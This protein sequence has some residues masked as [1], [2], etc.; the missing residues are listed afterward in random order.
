MRPWRVSPLDDGITAKKIVYEKPSFELLDLHAPPQALTTRSIST[1]AQVAVVDFEM[2]MHLAICT[3]YSIYANEA[4]RAPG[5][6]PSGPLFSADA[7][8]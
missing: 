6:K 3:K 2:V 5:Q 1:Q 4:A 7:C 8:S